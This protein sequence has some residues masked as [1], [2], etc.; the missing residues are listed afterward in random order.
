MKRL[1]LGKY[2]FIT[3]SLSL[4]SFLVG[5]G[6]NFGMGQAVPTPAASLPTAQALVTVTSLPLEQASQPCTN[7]FVAQNL[8]HTT[9]VSGPVTRLFESNGSGLAVG[10]LNRDNL[11]DLV[12]ANIGGTSTILWNQGNLNFTTESLADSHTRSVNIVDVD[13]DGWPDITFTHS[14]T[15]VTYWRNTG[16]AHPRFVQA[17]LPGV[18]HPAYTMAWGDLNGDGDLDLVTGSYDAELEK[19][20]RD[21]FLFGE[22]AGVFYYDHH[23]ETF[24]PQRLAQKSQALA[25]ALLDFNADGR[26]DIL[27]GNDFDLHDQAWQAGPS[28]W[29]EAT[30]FPKTPHSTMGFDLGDIN[31]D[32]APELFATDMKPYDQNVQRLAAWKPMMTTMMKHDLPWNDPQVMENVLQVRGGD[33]HFHNEAYARSVDATG[34]TWSAKFGDLN[35][36]GFLDLY[37]VN[38]MIAADLFGYLPGN[39][40]VEANQALRNQG[41]GYFTPAPEW[42]LGSTAS[43]RGMSLADLNN[44]GNLDIVIN[45]LQSPAQLFENRLCGGSSVEVDLFWPASANQRALGAQLALHTSAGTYYRDVRAASGYLSGDPARIH[46]GFPARAELQHLDITWPDGQVSSINSVAAQTLMTITR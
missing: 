23:G 42:G 46:F 10:D 34:W 5:C 33:G 4:L 39:E 16:Q 40:L 38:G 22:G 21:S 13:G 36:D 2:R 18:D 20:L 43:G 28:G 1:R 9:T 15:G 8:N 30:P 41:N 3:T 44:D 12:F 25:L 45:N 24:A 17:A 6:P 14:T 29:V 11:L 37:A 26:L 32:G 31:N 35:N 19:E 7:S 27:V